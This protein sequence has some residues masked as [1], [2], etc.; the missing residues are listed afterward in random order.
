MGGDT[1]KQ[2]IRVKTAIGKFISQ[3]N[4]LTLPTQSEI[5]GWLGLSYASM[6][7][8]MELDGAQWHQLMANVDKL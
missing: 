3:V 1:V 6:H 5:G 4:F 7:F 2:A 8:K